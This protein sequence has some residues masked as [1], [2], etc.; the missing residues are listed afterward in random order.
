[1][2]KV[3]GITM[4]ILFWIEQ[5]LAP[6]ACDSTAFFYDEMESQSGFCL[7]ILYQPFDPANPV[8]WLDRGQIFDF[9][10]ATGGPG[11]TLLDFG[12]GDGWP[13]L[14][15]APYSQKVVGVDGSRKRVAVC[16][17]NA[18]RLGIQ[19][20]FFE[21]IPPGS[22]L[23]FPDGSF[24]GVT[25]A[26]SVE[27]SPDPLATLRELYR[28]LRPGGRLRLSYESLSSYQGGQ[29]RGVD[30]SPID[31]DTCWL[32]LYFRSIERER[33]RMARLK[34]GM[35]AEE[36]ARLLLAQEG[37]VAWDA[38]TRPL[39]EN[40]AAS[41]I[42]ART[43]TLTHPSGATYTRWLAE[44]GFRQ[45]QP[46]HNGGG[47]AVLLFNALPPE[48]RPSD[49]AGIDALLRPLVQVVVELQAPL[50]ITHG[51]EPWISAVK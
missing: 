45:V 32:T 6:R 38:L 8:H 24:D 22:L 20:A 31:A 15:V 33:A 25:A 18:R 26:S 46:T 4:E 41:V 1:M 2:G 5:H 10:Y 11:Q 39:L 40:L 7:P 3:G 17:E 30:I 14:L 47:A 9:L 42:E 43:C 51:Q 28:V 37:V 36:A 48:R 29:E 50:Q 12:P 35:P 16:R 44:I 27:Q 49:L 21:H 13:S 23:P 19:N 34:L